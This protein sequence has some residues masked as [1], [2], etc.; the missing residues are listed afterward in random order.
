M[1][2]QL[3]E[4]EKHCK[5]LYEQ[6]MSQNNKSVERWEDMQRKYEES[7]AK[8]SKQ[9]E[10]IEG[11]NQQILKLKDVNNQIEYSWS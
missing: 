11:L 1:K 3:K 6:L 8:L 9:L 5:D 2:T 10:A 7:Q 4:S